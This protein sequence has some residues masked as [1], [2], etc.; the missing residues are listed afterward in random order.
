M[1]KKQLNTLIRT[2]VLCLL[3]ATSATSSAAGFHYQLNLT[4]RL[5]TTP[6]G[7]LTG[8]EMS[9]IYDAELS[10]ILMD[11][12]DLSEAKRE[13]T[14]QRRAADILNGLFEMSY[15]TK[16]YLDKRPLPTLRVEQYNLQ[17]TDASQLQLNLTLPLKEAQSLIGH[18]LEV[19]V[20]D[21][22][23]VG[24]ATFLT[25]DRLLLNET[26]IGICKKPTLQQNQLESKGDHILM[27]ET[28]TID[29]R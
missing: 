18:Q 28:M 10:A 3:F 9:W 29:C 4:A 12:E 25:E 1:L 21:P 16:I 26:L 15:F 6:G 24:L 23:A 19:V 14:L 8:I 17:F 27:S 20:S 22:T 11:G 2:V 7:E 13:E 5:A